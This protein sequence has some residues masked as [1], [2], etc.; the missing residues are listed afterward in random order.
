MALP[1]VDATSRY[2]TAINHTGV[3]LLNHAI[4][5][6]YSSE[7]C[8]N[9]VSSSVR[10]SGFKFE[11]AFNELLEKPSVEDIAAIE[12]ILKDLVRQDMPLRTEDEVQPDKANIRRLRDVLYPLKARVIKMDDTGEFCC[13]THAD[14]TGQLKEVVI[15][16]FRPNGD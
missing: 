15:R 2:S 4:R 3:H 14:S 10:Q 13:G 9:Q 16:S 8:I 6:Y 11:F 5:K 12:A 1:Q 7:T